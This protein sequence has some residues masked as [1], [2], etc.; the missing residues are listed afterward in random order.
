MCDSGLYAG[1]TTAQFECT[2]FVMGTQ[3]KFNSITYTIIGLMSDMT[4]GSGTKDVGA[5]GGAGSVT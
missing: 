3:V 5:F 2:N 4:S 1:G